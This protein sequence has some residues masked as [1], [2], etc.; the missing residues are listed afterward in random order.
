MKVRD[1]MIYDVIHVK[2][3]DS[4][5]SLLRKLAQFKIGGVPVVDDNQ[6]LVGMVS[7]G[8]VL[9]AF[10]PK[11]QTIFDFYTMVFILN[12]REVRETVRE[13][14]D[15]TVGQIMTK[16]KL[17]YVHPDDEFEQVLK[18]LSRHHFKKIPVINHAGRVV[19]VISRGDVIRFITQ[20]MTEGD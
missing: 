1:F 7:D 2:K 3:D 10:D 15:N 16:R 17:F 4:V 11:E 5:R 6:N 18:I 13:V 20:Q 8:D 14:I 9:R 19:G 12:K